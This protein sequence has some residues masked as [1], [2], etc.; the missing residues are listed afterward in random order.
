MIRL[1]L[2]RE[3]YPLDLGHGV[4]VTVAVT[5]GTATLHGDVTV[6]T[7][8]NGAAV[9]PGLVLSGGAGTYQLQFTATGLTPAVSEPI[10]L[11]ASRLVLATQPAE[12]AVN[13]TVL[14]RQPAVRVADLNGTPVP[15]AGVPVTVSLSGTGMLSGL[16]PGPGHE[17]T[18][19]AI[20]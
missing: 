1:D 16:P 20:L 18:R 2:K 10:T 5:A 15:Q 14:T 19:A 3:P 13:G 8:A 6:A 7:G 12:T 4:I 11:A 9:F 17:D